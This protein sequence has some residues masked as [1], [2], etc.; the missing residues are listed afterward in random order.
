MHLGIIFLL[1]AIACGISAFLNGRHHWL[2]L[3]PA[4]S[5]LIVSVAYF[6][7][8]PRLLGKRGNGKLHPIALIIHAP[9]LLLTWLVFHVVATLRGSRDASEVAKGVWL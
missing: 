4:M 3:W 8:G 6:G 5:F 7:G 9:Y 1:F 2:M